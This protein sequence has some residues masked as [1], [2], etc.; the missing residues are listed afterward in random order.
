MI[1]FTIFLWTWR[2]QLWQP[3]HETLDKIAR[4]YWSMSKTDNKQTFF[5]GKLLHKLC[6]C[7][8][9]NSVDSPAKEF[10]TGGWKIYPQI[11]KVVWIVFFQEQMFLQKYSYGKVYCFIDNTGEQARKKNRKSFA[12][13]PE[14]ITKFCCFQINFSTQNFLLT[15]G[16][17]CSQLFQGKFARR[18]KK[19]WSSS[20]KD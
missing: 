12:D 14:M 5:R 9:E 11:L 10:S 2:T 8:R 17:Q 16:A 20:E 1:I 4:I 15:L 13:W 7:T 19:N 6:L 3:G 18:L